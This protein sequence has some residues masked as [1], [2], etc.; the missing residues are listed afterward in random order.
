M[1]GRRK[2]IV[3]CVGLLGDGAVGDVE[4]YRIL[5]VYG[6]GEGEGG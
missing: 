1:R 5:Q 3:L 4:F 6:R 2:V